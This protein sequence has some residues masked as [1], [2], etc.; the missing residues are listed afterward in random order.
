M[1]KLFLNSSLD[2]GRKLAKRLERQFD[3]FVGIECTHAE[4]NG[5]RI[6]RLQSF[7]DEGRTVKAGSH[8]NAAR[9]V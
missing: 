3:L 1:N 5:T 7:V 6:G 2:R 9:G 8:L 4:S